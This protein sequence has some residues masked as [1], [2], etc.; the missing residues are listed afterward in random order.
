M[1]MDSDTPSAVTRRFHG[2]CSWKD[3]GLRKHLLILLFLPWAAPFSLV[4]LHSPLQSTTSITLL[5]M[6]VPSVRKVMQQK[7]GT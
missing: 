1:N 3:G 7:L 5:L 6:Q 2:A 4:N